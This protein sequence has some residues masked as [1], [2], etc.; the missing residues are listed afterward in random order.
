MAQMSQW[1]EDICFSEAV[2][3]RVL[4]RGPAGRGQIEEAGGG[5]LEIEIGCRRNKIG[6]WVE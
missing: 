3:L 1:R 4:S 6:R 5:K 2:V